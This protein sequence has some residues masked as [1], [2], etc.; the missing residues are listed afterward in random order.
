MLLLDSI[1]TAQDCKGADQGYAKGEAMKTRKL[2]Y[3]QFLV[4]TLI[5]L[6][7]ISSC[8]STGPEDKDEYYLYGSVKDASGNPISGADVF[9]LFNTGY[10]AVS[11]DDTL[12]VELSSF[13][14]V[15]TA[16]Y[17]V[18]LTWITESETNLLGF[19]IYRSEIAN[20]ADAVLITPTLIYGTNT[21]SQQ[22]Y[23]FQD[24]EVISDTTYYYWLECVFMS[25]YSTFHGPV[26]VYVEAPDIPVLPEVPMVHS[27]Y[28][29]PFISLTNIG[30]AVPADITANVIISHPWYGTVKTFA[31]I[32]PG[33]YNLR[34]DGRNIDGDF[35]ANGLYQVKTSFYNSSDH[36]L[37]SFTHNLL[38]VKPDLINLPN[39]VTDNAGYKI[40]LKKFFQPGIDFTTTDAMGNALGNFQMPGN[41]SIVVR[42]AGYQLFTQALSFTDFSSDHKLD[43]TLTPKI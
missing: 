18:K 1:N 21:S 41:L 14:A 38:I 16:Q 26:S 12:E 30:V 40:P 31:P 32:N 25:G 3:F 24:N 39:Q 6:G 22:V 9:I 33:T 36:Y 37:I 17:M 11:R 19:R 20:Q 13:S 42:K 35:V 15:L 10:P 28:P 34:W 8:K 29:N 27:P 5:L 2:I 7:M 4:I 43:I 23:S